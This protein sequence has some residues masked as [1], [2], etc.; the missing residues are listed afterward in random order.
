MDIKKMIKEKGLSYT[1]AREELINLLL[2]ASTPLSYDNIKNSLSMDK[3]TFYRNTALFEAAEII[4][5]FESNDKKRYY[6][7]EQNLHPHFICTN[8]NS[9]EC[10]KEDIIYAL[11][12]Y[13]IESITIK[14][15]CPE[16]QKEN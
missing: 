8:C 4:S 1:Q 6:F 15:L 11:N 7:I 3:A 16:C 2:H 13:K 12:G 14:G 10:L 9:I 5:S